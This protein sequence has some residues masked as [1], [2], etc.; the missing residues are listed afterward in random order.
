II[1]VA[2]GDEAG[3]AIEIAEQ[4]RKSFNY[5]ETKVTILGHLQ[6]GG[7]PTCMDRV[8]AS[9]LGYNAV[10][11]LLEGHRGEMVGIIDKK[12]V[13]TPFENAI[14]HNVEINKEMLKMARILSS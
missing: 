12:V 1:I 14:K 7:S 5:Y 10:K 3:G 8:L 11:G 4:V 2:E 13:F 6:R 9:E